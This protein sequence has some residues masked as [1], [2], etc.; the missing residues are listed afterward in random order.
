MY[1]CLGKIQDQGSSSEVEHLSSVLKALG[2]VPTTEKTMN[3]PS[4]ELLPKIPKS[5]YSVLVL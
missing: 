5:I 2:L 3:L 1:F 4:S